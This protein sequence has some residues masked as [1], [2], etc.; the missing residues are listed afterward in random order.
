MKN[1]CNIVVLVTSIMFNVSA[2]AQQNTLDEASCIASRFVAE[3]S[4]N[5]R[6]TAEDGKVTLAYVE[7][8]K[9]PAYYVFN[10]DSGFVIVSGDK[11][12]KRQVLGYSDRGKFD[13]ENASD[14][15][16]ILLQAYSDVIGR[17]KADASVEEENEQETKPYPVVGPFIKSHWDQNYPSNMLM[18]MCTDTHYGP[19]ASDY[20]TPHH[21]KAGCCTIAMAMIMKYWEWPKSAKGSGRIIVVQDT[22]PYGYERFNYDFDSVYDWGHMRDE[23]GNWEYD[24][25]KCKEV[26]VENDYSITEALALATFIFD[27]AISINPVC[28]STGTG[29]VDE[30]VR[31]AFQKY[32]SYKIGSYDHW[33]KNNILL[34]LDRGLPVIVEADCATGGHAF[35]CDGYDSEGYCHFNMGWGGRDDGYYLLDSDISSYNLRINGYIV[36]IEPDYEKA[37]VLNVPVDNSSVTE[38]YDLQGRRIAQ[39][40][41]GIYIVNGKKVIK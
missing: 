3:H 30:M 20:D 28:H 32:F 15:L 14:H 29:S 24:E 23:Y 36:G 37:A 18:P 7:M 1:L 10:S 4:S 31:D 9:E 22:P 26:W 5:S 6:S 21:Y 12:T 13:Y 11:R 17:L 8:G 19:T 34:E 39:P 33:D 38:I 2:H 27:C 40:R 35:I 16:K 41:N 25:E